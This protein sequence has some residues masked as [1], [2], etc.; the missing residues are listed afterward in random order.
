MRE[1]LQEYIQTCQRERAKHSEDSTMETS[2]FPFHYRQGIQIKRMGPEKDGFLDENT[3]HKNANGAYKTA[4]INFK[5]SSGDTI[6][7]P[8]YIRTK[9]ITSLNVCLGNKGGERTFVWARTPTFIVLNL[10]KRVQR[11]KNMHISKH[12]HRDNISIFL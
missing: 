11:T 4:Q 12:K 1:R 10:N 7:K 3:L 2:V 9:M 5:R 8:V 6:G